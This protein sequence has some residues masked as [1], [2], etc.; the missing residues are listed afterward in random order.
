VS[1]E[2][3][4]EINRPQVVAEVVDDEVVAINLESGCYYSIRGLGTPVWLGVA[5]HASPAQIAA[6]LLERGDGDRAA[7][8]AA[9]VGFLAELERE[10]LIRQSANGAAAAE[11]APLESTSGKPADDAGPFEPPVLEKFTDMEDLLLLDPVHD[12]DAQGWPHIAAE[13]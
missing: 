2:A 6:A 12:V 3:G 8:E 7:V 10:G 11:T 9:V 13:R 5:R 4:Y 1:A